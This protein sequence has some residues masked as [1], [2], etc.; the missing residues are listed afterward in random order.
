[1]LFPRLITSFLLFVTVQSAVFSNSARQSTSTAA[2]LPKQALAFDQYDL[3]D[4]TSTAEGSGDGANLDEYAD[5]D[6]DEQLSKVTA[7]T[8]TIR[9]TMT[10]TTKR[11]E[12]KTANST[13]MM[14][15]GAN[16]FDDDYKDDIED[17]IDYN[18]ATTK[19]TNVPLTTTRSEPAIPPQKPLR[20]FFNFL[21]RPP[22]AAGIL[23]GLAIGILSS[24]VLLICLVQRF[25]K[26]QRTH[27]SYTTGLLYPSHYGYSKSPQEFYA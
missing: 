15:L 23:A 1:M 10:T 18:E 7:S 12:M 6:E 3:H 14:D 24:V 5:D 4:G 25:N 20:L 8:S 27:S 22:I 13:K 19:I 2:I 17:S 21:T 16:E 9:T 11:S 26:R